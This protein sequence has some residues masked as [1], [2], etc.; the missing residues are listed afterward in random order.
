[1]AKSAGAGPG[2]WR[3]ASSRRGRRAPR[4]RARG[5][6]GGSRRA[7]GSP[8]AGGGRPPAE[9]LAARTSSR[10]RAPRERRGDRR[11]HAAPRPAQDDCRSMTSSRRVWLTSVPGDRAKSPGAVA[12]TRRTRSRRRPGDARATVWARRRRRAGPSRERRGRRA[13]RRPARAG[14]RGRRAGGS[15]V[16]RS[17][18]A[19]RPRRPCPGGACSGRGR[20]RAGRRRRRTTRRADSPESNDP[21]SK[22]TVCVRG[23]TFDHCTDSPG[24]T[25]TCAGREGL[26]LD[27]DAGR[28]GGRG[29][30][31]GRAGRKQRRGRG[32]DAGRAP[33]RRATR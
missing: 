29:R 21:S 25:S 17:R 3:A 5:H 7:R 13:T 6:A 16:E 9:A 31:G 14:R 2:S 18:G 23:L 19:R 30:D 24:S 12:V 32:R 4:A 28:P 8:G 33:H 27:V 1:M 11:R 15:G 22:V 10:T 26:E 20:R